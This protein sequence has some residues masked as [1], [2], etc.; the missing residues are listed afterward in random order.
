MI[1]N[2][3]LG[4]DPLLYTTTIPQRP[5][6]AD[7]K[8]QLDNMMV[9][10]Q[11]LQNQQQTPAP[12][13]PTMPQ[14]DYLG[15][16]DQT[17]KDAGEDVIKLLSDNEEFNRLNIGIQQMLQFEIMRDARDRINSNPDAVKNIDRLMNIIN[18][19]KKT[20][21]DENN[22]NMAELNDY[23]RNY[24]DLTF[25]EYKQLKHGN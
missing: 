9:Q 6:E 15:I 14:K 24:S 21:E 11:M 22:K 1:N 3:M 10:Y 20:K 16:L 19:A 7:L 23:I 18:D 12:Q 8:K 25:N 5:Q 17:I 13:M 4:Q 2:I